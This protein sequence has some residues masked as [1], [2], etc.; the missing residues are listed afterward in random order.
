MIDTSIG[1]RALLG[2]IAG[3]GGAALLPRLAR[4][5][6]T[7][8]INERLTGNIAPVHDPA[9]IRQGDTY[10]LFT[11]G[12]LGDAE[13]LIGWRTSTDLVSWTLGAPVFAAIP[14]WAKEAIPG[15][16]GLWAPDIIRVGD[17]YRLYYSV[18]TFG[19]N[20]SAIGLVTT[21][22]LDR[23]AP[24]FGWTDKGM[25]WE[26]TSS[27]DHNAIDPN[28][29]VDRE[30]RHWMSFGSFWTGL[31]LVELDSATG[32]PLPG[33]KLHAIARRHRPGAVEAPFIIERDGY[34]YLFASYD[35][36]CRGE[37]STYY[38][39]VG[40]SKD[41][42]G[43]YEGRDGK[44]M[45]RSGGLLVLHAELD[46]TKRFVGPGHVSI[47]RESEQ[48]YIVYHAY[49]TKA[50]GAPTLRIQPLA[51]TPDGWPVAL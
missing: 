49:D 44:S 11:T 14:D 37:K 41:I 39:V 33:A 28:I 16:G 43:P 22:T 45:M 23:S 20:R 17:E 34:Y 51:W 35:F 4:A 6:Q 32:K 27:S 15:T 3:V 7:G 9:I 48:D 38:T 18:S 1:R 12:N 13:G 8:S 2:S 26:S 31:K 19:K 30:G 24:G 40:R 29:V 36:C 47:L 10:H 46:E 5:S 25:V 42:A 50:D 21:P